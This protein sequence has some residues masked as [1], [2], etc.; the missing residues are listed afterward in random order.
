MRS[1]E[2]DTAGDILQ[3]FTGYI[4][5]IKELVTMEMW[6]NIFMN[7]SKNEVLVFWLLYRQKEVN[8]SEIAEYIHVPL[9]TATGIISR[10]ENNGLVERKRSDADKRIVL[11]TYSEKGWSIFQKLIN[12]LMS[13]TIRIMGALSSDELKLVESLMTKVKQV[14]KEEKIKKE[15][16]KKVRRITIE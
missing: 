3:K 8:M 10:M 9:N 12:E 16:V 4:E 11:I 7:C 5:E 15:P 2:Q 14:M 13:Y 6:E 1:K